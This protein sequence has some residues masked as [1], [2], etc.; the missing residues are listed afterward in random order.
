MNGN[1]HETR[2]VHEALCCAVLCHSVMPDSLRPHGLY[3]LPDSSVHGDSLGKNIGVGYHGLLQGIFQTQGLNP[4]LP[5]CRWI[6]YHLSYW[7]SPRILEWVAYP[8]SGG[9]FRPRNQMG[10][11]CIAG[12]FFILS[13]IFA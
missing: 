1:W 8:F 4:A 3:S 5:H 13:Q 11:Y 6:L 12:R 7:G 2:R 10:V 9:T